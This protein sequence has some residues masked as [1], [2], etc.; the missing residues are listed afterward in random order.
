MDQ[1]YFHLQPTST[2]TFEEVGSK[3]VA[4]IGKEEKRAATLQAA[5]SGNG[6]VLPYHIIYKG[7]TAAS[8]P[9]NSCEGLQ[10][11]IDLGFLFDFSGTNSYWST[12]ELMCKW[13]DKILVPYWVRQKECVGAP[14]DQECI[15]YFDI[16]AVHCSVAFRTWL[17]K[18]Y[19]WIKYRYVPAGM[20]GL[21]QP[22][23]VG[24]QRAIKL[25]IK[26][27]QHADIVDETLGL[28][29]AGTAAN[30]L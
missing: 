28:L 9:H 2:S 20:T 14:A 25:V 4:V 1:T 17:D 18:S 23:D 13:V 27:S 6:D 26:Q 10:E 16:W 15:L 29:R 24:M 30:D 11:A 5:V 22:C 12:F 7:K 3:Q 8:L 21:A 19:P